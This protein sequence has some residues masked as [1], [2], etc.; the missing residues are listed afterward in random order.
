MISLVGTWMQSTAQ[1]FL[2]YELTGSPA[3]LGYVGFAAGIP[4][5][6]FSL[7]GGMISD[8]MSKRNMMVLTQSAMMILAFALAALTFAGRVQAWQIVVMAFL[9]G[10]ANAFDA[11]ARQ[12]FVLEMVDRE[13]LTNAIALNATM[14]NLATAVGPAVAGITYAVFGPAW[15]FTINGISFIAV[16][17]ALLLMKLK[18]VTRSPRTDSALAEIRQGIGY[19]ISNRRVRT[20]ILNLGV[21]SLFGLGFVT[22]MPAWA[23][24]ILG[25]DATTN[26]LLQS[27][28]GIGAFIGALMLAALGGFIPRGRLFTV[29]SFVFPVL[30]FLYAF[31][32]WLP[33]SLLCLVGIGWGFMV[34]VNSSNVLVQTQVPDE[35]RG[36]VMSI[37]TLSFFGL[38]PVGAFIAGRL[39]VMIGEPPTVV[40]GALILFAFALWIRLRVPEVSAAS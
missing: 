34:M 22:L 35:L 7:Y 19:V 23:V 2:V 40:A 15:C 12:A 11:P 9:L 26:G 36:R 14:F 5:W 38:M 21:V 24:E 1:A 13:D 20:V 8:R 4:A 16:I 10:I 33:L 37:F 3:Y 27:A 31:L 17:S 29:G 39:A 25:G 32:R 6:L 30:G 18:P 28:R